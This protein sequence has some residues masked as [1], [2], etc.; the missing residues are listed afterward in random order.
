L[1]QI[2]FFA[3]CNCYVFLN[4]H[5]TRRSFFPSYLRYWQIVL[6]FFIIIK[7]C[8]LPIVDSEYQGR[9]VR[10]CNDRGSLKINS[11]LISEAK[12]QGLYTLFAAFYLLSD[13]TYILTFQCL[14][15][16]LFF[17]LH[18]TPII[19]IWHYV[20]EIFKPDCLYGFGN[21]LFVM[22]NVGHCVTVNTEA[23][24]QIF[25]VTEETSLHMLIEDNI[26]VIYITFHNFNT[27]LNSLGVLT[28]GFC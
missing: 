24:Q 13:V 21:S 5:L 9:N 18:C 20:F 16:P 23:W 6:L 8:L 2:I 7:C 12:K 17:F 26:S 14:L 1:T 28:E 3:F 11:F 22:Y 25:T 19:R 4:S 27:N 10:V 15:C